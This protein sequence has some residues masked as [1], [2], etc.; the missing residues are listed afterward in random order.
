LPTAAPRD[1]RVAR[2]NQ[3]NCKQ[4]KPNLISYTHQY[5]QQ[6]IRIQPIMSSHSSKNQKQEAKN[7]DPVP[8]N[9]QD[10]T[11]KQ[12]NPVIVPII[13][14]SPNEVWKKLREKAQQQ[15]DEDVID[16]DAVNEIVAAWL[17]DTEFNPLNRTT[18]SSSSASSKRKRGSETDT[19]DVPL[20]LA[21]PRVPRLCA[22]ASSPEDS[23][24]DGG[25]EAE[26]RL[27]QDRAVQV[28][29]RA[30]RKRCKRRLGR[31]MRKKLSRDRAAKRDIVARK[32]E[33]LGRIGEV[34]SRS[35]SPF[36]LPD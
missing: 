4:I 34:W 3:H 17:H 8:V 21:L 22:A 31:T 13:Q 33:K 32:M 9:T 35:V 23:G 26:G 27:V 14:D 25:D 11:K 1:S 18:G 28:L 7:D 5:N 19:D 29:V 15:G 12:P 20:R 2:T 10:T 16:L 30:T 36:E 6:R 24:Y